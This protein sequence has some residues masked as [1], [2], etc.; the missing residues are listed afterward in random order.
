MFWVYQKPLNDCSKLMT[1]NYT[2]WRLY[3]TLS[4][5]NWSWHRPGQAEEGWVGGGGWPG[6]EPI[7]VLLRW[8]N[9]FMINPLLAISDIFNQFYF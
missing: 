4:Y 9:I 1:N 7:S 6:R 2:S 5:L 8:D 3:Q